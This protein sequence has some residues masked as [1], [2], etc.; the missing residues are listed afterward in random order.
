MIALSLGV[1]LLTFAH[2]NSLSSTRLRVDGRTID[3]LMR[4]QVESL[5]EVIPDLDADRDGL[6]SFP[7]LEQGSPEILDYIA[8][9]YRVFTGTDREMEG[10]ELLL[11]CGLATNPTSDSD[12]PFGPLQWGEYGDWVDVHLEY[13]ATTEI[14]DL[15]VEIDLF[16]DT[17]PAHYDVTSIE[18]G[19]GQTSTLVLDQETPRRRSDPSVGGALTGFIRLG[20]DHILG[21]FDHLAFVFALV[22]ASRSYKKLIG[23]VTAFTVAHSITLG[24]TAVG[25][26]DF[27]EHS[28]LIEAGIAL[29]IAYVAMEQLVFPRVDRSR[30]LEAFVFGLIHG[31]GFAGFL[32]DS[33]VH[34]NRK[35][36]ALFGFNVGVELGQLLVVAALALI[37]FALKRDKATE[38]Q[39]FLA[40]RWLRIAGC[41]VVAGLGFYWF[42]E[43]IL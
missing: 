17:S 35:L 31:L 21:G 23:V 15:V 9:H 4:C 41:L 1:A 20:F 28:A 16:F 36:V 2:P 29:S 37:L 27:S 25:W 10:G 6:V 18:W 43:R 30:W 12:R 32:A 7:E 40:P 19:E 3:V 39:K 5:R 34:E 13:T 38:D 14:R 26:F 11:A 22:L 8:N 33:L 24:A 42:G